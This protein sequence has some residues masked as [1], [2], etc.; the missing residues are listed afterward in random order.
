[1]YFSWPRNSQRPKKI[2]LGLE[3]KYTE[4]L[5]PWHHG[6]LDHVG[7]RGIRVLKP[8]LSVLKVE[9]NRRSKYSFVT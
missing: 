3:T 1:M 8:L 4:R 9:T 6:D 7:Y 2:N 5:N